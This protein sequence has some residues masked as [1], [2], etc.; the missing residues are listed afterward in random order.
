MSL[1]AGPPVSIGLPVYNGE[2]FL[3]CALDSI[4]AQTHEG[5]ELVISDNASS[6][7]TEEICRHYAAGDERI[8]YVRQ[9]ENLG[10][11]ANF[12]LV[13]ELAR[14]RY[15][16]WASHD[17]LVEPTNLER[18]LAAFEDG[19]EDLVLV[20]PKTAIIDEAGAVVEQYEDGI[21]LFEPRAAARVAHLVSRLRLC[22]PV[23]GLIRSDAFARTRRLGS[24]L[25]ADQVLLLELA[26]LGRFREVPEVLFRRR[27][28]SARSAVASRRP[29]ARA[30][31]FDS[32]A[33]GR[34]YFPRWRLLWESQRAVVA[35]VPGREKLVVDG[36][37][38]AAYLKRHWRGLG[39]DLR[40]GAALMLSRP[41]SS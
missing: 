19:P 6:D 14:G 29:D 2:R 33:S 31:W 32:R 21:D 23:F 38:W 28:H 35:L 26:L 18:C 30:R 8:R 11:G 4:L 12:N 25:G 10:A 27:L 7:A 41:Q 34:F 17:D 15:F 22:N 3:A 40:R 1:S 9:E 20:Y 39:G 13:F 36:V 24:Y 16:R 5:F 37:L